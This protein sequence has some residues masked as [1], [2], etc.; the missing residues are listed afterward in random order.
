MVLVD[1]DSIAAG[2]EAGADVDAEAAEAFKESLC[3]KHLDRAKAS[4]EAQ[5]LRYECAHLSILFTEGLFL[6]IWKMWQ[7]LLVH[8]L[9][10][11]CGFSARI[12]V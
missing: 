12:R 1:G 5:Y 3:G 4:I 8:H 7:L 9:Q 11:H 10:S 6:V 2:E